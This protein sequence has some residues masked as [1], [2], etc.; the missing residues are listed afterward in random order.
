MKRRI[1]LLV[2]AALLLPFCAYCGTGVEDR[3]LS[4]FTEADSDRARALECSLEACSD[5]G[6]GFAEAEELPADIPP[7]ERYVV[8]F[9]DFLS[10]DELYGLVADREYRLLSDSAERVFLLRLPDRDAF[11][12]EHG[13]AVV[14]CCPDRLL[15]TAALPFDPE[16]GGLAEYECLRMAEAWDLVT[17][18]SSVTVAVLDTGISRSHEDLA[19]TSILNGYDFVERHAGVQKDSTGHGTAVTGLIAASANNGIGTAGVAYGVRILPVR[20]AAGSVNIYS[21]DLV[22]GLRFAADAGAGIL[23]LSFGGYTYSAAENDA[24]QY[25]RSKGCILIAAAGNGGGTIREGE[26]CYPA[27]Y[28]GVISVGSC[29]SEGNRSPFSQRSSGVDVLAPGERMLLLALDED[30][31]STYVHD[32]GTS[33]SAA[34]FSGLTALALS[35]LDDGVRF[36]SGEMEAMLA[37]LGVRAEGSGI[38]FADAVRLLGEVNLPQI[39]GVRNGGVYN[40]KVTIGFNRGSA[41]LDG[42]DFSDGETVYLNGSHELVVTEGSVRRTVRFRLN[43]VPASY[44]FH[45]EADGVSFTFRGGEAT[46]DGAPYR[47]GEKITFPG[48][49][50]FVLTDG[51]GDELTKRFFFDPSLPS[52]AG[53]ED[54]GEYASPVQIRISSGGEV[55]LDGEPVSRDFIVSE[56]GTHV[57]TVRSGNGSVSEDISFTVNTGAE[58]IENDLSRCRLILDEPNGW[59]AVY[60]EMLAGMRVYSLADRSFLGFLSTGSVTGYVQSEDSL[61]VFGDW[62]LSVID[63]AS[64]ADGTFSMVTH[65]IRCKGFAALDGGAYCLTDEGLNAVD[66]ETGELTLLRET[67][68]DEL[69]ASGDALWLIRDGQ[70]EKLG[71]EWETGEVVPLPFSAVGQKKLFSDGLLFCAGNAFDPETGSVR[72]CYAGYA[73]TVKDGLLYTTEGVYALENGRKAGRYDGTVSDVTFGGTDTYICGYAGGIRV[74]PENPG[75]AENTE[76][77]LPDAEQTGVFGTQYRLYE[78]PSAMDADGDR[79]ALAFPGQR[80]LTLSDGGAFSE[81]ALPFSPVGVALSGDSVCAWSEVCVWIDGTLTVPGSP[82]RSC[83]FRGGTVFALCDALLELRDGSWQVFAACDTCAAGRGSLAAWIDGGT[84]NV[85]LGGRRFLVACFAEKLLTDGAY[86]LADRRIYLASESGLRFLGELPSQ[87]S[88]VC[89]GYAFTRDGLRSLTDPE[90]VAGYDLTGA[91]LVSLSEGCGGLFCADGLL[92]RSD[93]DRSSSGGHPVWEEPTMIGCEEDALYNRQTT[94]VFDRGVCY[95]DGAPCTSGTVVRESGAHVLTLLLPCGRAYVRHFSVIPA[96]ESISFAVPRY[97]LAV[98]ETG[99]LNII[100]YPKE[101]SAVPLTYSVEGDCIELLEGGFFSAVREGTAVVTAATTDGAHSASCFV[102]V[103]EKLIRFLPEAGYTVDRVNG[104]LSGVRAGTTPEEL[105]SYVLADGEVSVSDPLLCTGSALTLYG[106]DGEVL[107]ELTVAVTGDLDGDGLLSVGDLSLLRE[108]LLAGSAPDGILSLAADMNRSGRVNDRDFRE[109]LEWVLFLRGGTHRALPAVTSH[110]KARLFLPVMTVYGGDTVSV[111]VMLSGCA[112][113]GSVSGRLLFDPAKY[114]FAGSSLYDWE[115][116]TGL[117]EGWVSF[118]ADGEAYSGSIPV[119]SF[120]FRVLGGGDAS[121][122]LVLRDVVVSG[123]ELRS[124]NTEGLTPESAVRTYGDLRLTVQGMTGEFRSDVQSYEVH[125]PYGTPGLVYD[126]RY[127]EGCT[128]EVSNAMFLRSDELTASFR[129]WFREGDVRTYTVHAFR[130]GIPP[131]SDNCALASLTVEGFPFDFDPEVLEYRITVPYDVEK[132]DIRWEAEDENAEVL[133]GSSAL[134]QGKD[135][136]ITVTVIA[137]DGTKRIYRLL[138]RREALPEADSS[139]ELPGEDPAFGWVFAA[140]GASL[141]VGGAAFAFAK[142]KKKKAPAENEA[143]E[144]QIE[145]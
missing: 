24:V 98:G 132:A 88:A 141:A 135:N 47:D 112:D 35:V 61:L 9:S 3:C 78:E 7:E 85:Q 111:T 72:F 99:A 4:A 102:T 143:P 41:K 42:E 121:P 6:S 82:V 14:Y 122:D 96:L 31:R 107:D 38:G 126:L 123:D 108:Y 27:S 94:V 91:K 10:E 30:G 45:E 145:R 40:G 115:V 71:P 92:V 51:F 144:G 80:K 29:D 28:D 50:L 44:T 93:Y 114:V 116:E 138:I 130:S 21:S 34:V 103:D 133:C 23:N 136:L 37:G 117:G 84:L 36:G 54:G 64:L 65:S 55:T 13:D 62:Q 17:A 109:L 100:Y 134:R 25:A 120:Q 22:N 19:L 39:T 15:E 20:I 129:F 56:D 128:A 131:K 124:V 43:Y 86:V 81:I 140:V 105:L 74:F 119:V 118:A 49:H 68:A 104:T 125:L 113:A 48:W 59:Y 90:N 46:L 87:P 60:G 70:A 63:P 33:F 1:A 83:F 26:N 57:L 79:F 67:D 11:M 137:E 69:C 32:S 77:A 101:T 8:R 2:A 52:V 16:V 139:E 12:E 127:P 5:P 58:Y 106:E 53:V 18:D 66:T 73:L 110:G 95:L 75:Y 142:R 89:G 97:H 76:A